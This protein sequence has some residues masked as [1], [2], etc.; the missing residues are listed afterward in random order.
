MG[1]EGRRWAT[2]EDVVA[3]ESDFEALGAA[4]DATGA[5][6][7][8]RVGAGEARLMRQ[9]ELVAFGVAWMTE[10]R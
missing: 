1:P 4:F 6:A 3:D 8:G 5:V 9:R 10:H 7:I 2:W